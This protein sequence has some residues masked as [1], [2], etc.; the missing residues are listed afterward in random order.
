MFDR[1]VYSSSGII[2]L[3]FFFLLR[4]IEIYTFI[5]IGNGHAEFRCREMGQVRHSRYRGQR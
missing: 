2:Y 1:S 4:V 5:A 3:R